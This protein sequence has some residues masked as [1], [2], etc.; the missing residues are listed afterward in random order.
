MKGKDKKKKRC[1]TKLLTIKESAGEG[2]VGR[3]G[4]RED[5]GKYTGTKKKEHKEGGEVAKST[6]CWV[7]VLF[8]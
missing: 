8:S 4:K 2:G 6:N 1:R 5:G 3:E 7:A